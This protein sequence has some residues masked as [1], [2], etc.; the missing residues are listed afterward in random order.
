MG[1]LS[2]CLTALAIGA[3][4]NTGSA[5][6][7]RCG[8]QLVTIGDSKVEVLAKCGEPML[9]DQREEWREE[10]DGTTKR[11]VTTTVDEWTYNFGPGEFVQFLRFEN[12]RVVEVT[13]GAYGSTTGATAD[14]CRH[15]QL[16]AVG[17]SFAEVLLKCGEPVLQERRED[18]IIETGEGAVKRRESVMVDDWTYNFGPQYFLYFVRFEN[19]RIKELRTG[20]YG[21]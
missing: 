14:R 11:R 8:N 16:L 19:G 6:A 3:L 1:K 4:V 12:G 10:V 15:G 5:L 9:K 2:I 21:Y 17:D 7:L 18:R 20:G 13:S